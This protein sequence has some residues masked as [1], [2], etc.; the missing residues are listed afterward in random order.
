M[1]TTSLT[2][3]YI[4]AVTRQLPEETGPDVA[5]ELRGTLA[6]TVE[7]RVAAGEEPERAER[8][9]LADLGDPD[10]LAREY[11]GRP[12]HLVGPSIYA[13]YVRLI[14][15]MLTVVLPVV[16]L[17]NVV[18]QL[19]AADRGLGDLIGHS[20]WGVIETTVHL[21]FWT[22]LA[23]VLVERGRSE[24]DRD[25]PLS[26]WSPDQL[27]V[28]DVPWRKPGFG[29]MVTEVCG[30]VIL[31]LLVAWQF[32]GVGRGGVQVLNPD[33]ALGWKLAIIASFVV[34]ALVAVAAW[35]AGR[36][37]P[38][39]ALVN[40]VANIAAAIILV[41]LLYADQLLTDLPTVLGEQFGLD[42]DWSVSYP[43][44]VALIVAVCGWDVLSSATKAWRARHAANDAAA[45]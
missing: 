7:D 1:S 23:F 29:Q 33:L 2:D 19:L 44:T 13:D 39:L 10:V 24:S 6:D 25:K 36:W 4:W 31:A 11:G 3:R 5:R 41:W 16:V 34:D 40:A 43:A 20:V 45:Q 26:A 21:V 15:V 9:A 38:V 8:D 17:I 32:S 22:T 28:S 27:L 42:T 30:G 12:Q 14:K 37:T 18:T 35:R